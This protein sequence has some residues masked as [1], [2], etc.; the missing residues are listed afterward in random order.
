MMNPALRSTPRPGAASVLALLAALLA[1]GCSDDGTTSPVP[2]CEGVHL[3]AF[4]SDRGQTAGLTKIYLYDLDFDGFRAIPGLEGTGAER[5]PAIA[6]DR[7]SM[8]YVANR[9]TS[10]D[11][12][13][14]YDRCTDRIL[15]VGDIVTNFS[16]R[17]PAFSGDGKTLAFVRDTTASQSRLRLFH[18]QSLQ[19][20]AVPDVDTLLAA[21]TSQAAHPTLNQTATVIAFAANLGT[22]WDVYVYDRGTNTIRDLP[23]LRSAGNDEDPWLTPDGRFLAFASDR[24][25]GA[26][27]Y[28]VY[29]YDL[30]T[31]TFVTLDNLN[32]AQDDRDPTMT[33]DH[34]FIVFTSSRT[35]AGAHGAVDL[36]NYNVSSKTLSQRVEQSS[37]GNDVTP[38]LVWP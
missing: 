32:S 22:G 12:V 11:D 20:L 35:G 33:P 2:D 31:T 36:W 15:E 8:A 13:L 10:G 6:S 28:D 4:A 18:G 34:N 30:Q 19:Y 38:Y 26:G 27:G 17:D 7:R 25:G 21:G 23:D 24:S 3:L 14:F 37:G 9:G 5:D 1:G 16:E 29:L